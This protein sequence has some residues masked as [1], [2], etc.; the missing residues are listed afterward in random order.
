MNP[1]PPL[2][3]EQDLETRL[4]ALLLG[5][6]SETEAIALCQ[7]ME[8]D[9]RLAA[10]YERLKQT[11]ALVRET[12][13]TPAAAPAVG[14]A[15]ANADTATPLRLPEDRRER[16]LAQFKT[17][18]VFT[19]RPRRGLPWFVPLTAAAAAVALLG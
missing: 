9:P 18:K 13:S 4:T 3:P 12:A 8:R 19:P 7:A 16:L 6:L 2:P 17:V 5:E 1:N 15:D 14:H 10:L 11:V